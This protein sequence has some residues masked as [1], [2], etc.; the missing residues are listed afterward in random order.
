MFDTFEI[1]ST[2]I[3]CFSKLKKTTHVYFQ[4]PFRSKPVLLVEEGA[5]HY[6]F[7]SIP[8]NFAVGRNFSR[9][10]PF[11]S[12]AMCLIA[13]RFRDT[14]RIMRVLRYFLQAKYIS[15]IV[16]YCSRLIFLA[17][18]PSSPSPTDII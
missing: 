9:V 12:S 10:Y 14:M 17:F 11:I 18:E 2:K 16:L 8:D 15:A 3:Q 13:S 6:F 4:E 5:L 1:A 7:R